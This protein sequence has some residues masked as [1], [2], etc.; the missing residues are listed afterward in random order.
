LSGGYEPTISFWGPLEGEYVAEQTA[1]LFPLVM[2][3]E[4]EDGNADGLGRV[5]S[6]MVEDTVQLDTTSET[7]G[8]VP[9]SLPDYVFTRLLQPLAQAQPATTVARLENAFF[10]WIGDDPLRGTPRVTLQRE[11]E[12]ADVFED[13]VRASG[14]PVQD[15]DLILTWTPNPIQREP[16]VERTHYY[17]V[18]FQAAAPMGMPG[19]GAVADRVGLPTGRYRFHVEGPGYSLDSDPFTVTVAELATMVEASGSDAT[20]TVGF[21]VPRGYRVLTRSGRSTGFVPLRATELTVNVG[22]GDE[23]MTTDADGRLS[24][25]GAVGAEVTITDAHGNTVT[26]TP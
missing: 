8:T 13:V 16:G 10:T 11:G 14:R 24:L 21:D 26:L 4:R 18:E 5:A 9:S 20:V 3:P 25:T 12:T 1:A 22:G 15:G 2:S 17:T 23:L 19:L 7:P 6:P